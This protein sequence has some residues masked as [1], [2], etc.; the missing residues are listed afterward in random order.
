[1]EDISESV[2]VDSA[3]SAVGGA[4]VRCGRG[5]DAVGDCCW[6]LVIGETLKA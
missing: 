6:R 3:Q 1:M 5:I 2:S 4:C